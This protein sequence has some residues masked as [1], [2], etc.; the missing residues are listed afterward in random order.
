MNAAFDELASLGG[1]VQ[2]TPGNHPTPAFEEHVTQFRRDVA[3]RSHHGFD[4][5]RR[6]RDVWDAEGNCLV[7]AHSV[8]PP[9]DDA[10]AG[11]AIRARGIARWLETR[12]RC[13]EPLL[14]TMY[15]GYLLGTGDEIEEAMRL[16]TPLAVDVSHVFMQLHAGAMNEA[17]WKRLAN[18][19]HVEE[20]HVSANSGT[21]DAHAPLAPDT[22][23]L[24]W[25]RERFADGTPTVLECYMFR[26]S[27]SERAAQIDLISGGT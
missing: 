12:A 24:A 5:A 18:Y 14:E 1:A 13:R 21:H 15:P 20:V 27:P 17:T 16:R 10:A 2:L 11:E 4:F 26:L 19:E 8:H 7:G 3:T 9:Q 25:A 6:R 23:G 22:F